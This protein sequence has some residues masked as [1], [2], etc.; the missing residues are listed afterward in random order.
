[1]GLRTKGNA[2]VTMSHRRNY[3]K[4]TFWILGELGML[5]QTL[6]YPRHS[7]KLRLLLSAEAQLRIDVMPNPSWS[8]KKKMAQ[9]KRSLPSYTNF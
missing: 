2:L 3:H 6:C 5:V 1:M 9:R 8:R 4:P 7:M